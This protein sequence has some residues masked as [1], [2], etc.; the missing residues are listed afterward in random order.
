MYKLNPISSLAYLMEYFVVIIRFL[1]R[2]H[3][4]CVKTFREII[5]NN[6]SKNRA[7]TALKIPLKTIKLNTKLAIF[8]HLEAKTKRS[9][10][11]ND[12]LRIF[13]ARKA[14][15]TS[16]FRESRKYHRKYYF[17]ALQTK[18]NSWMHA[19]IFIRTP[20]SFHDL[21]TFN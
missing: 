16:T 2:R 5:G 10:I 18:L 1:R 9:Q 19:H 8:G 4:S 12:F 20:Y 21:V 6:H 14:L 17:L 11:N 3:K 13:R 7:K 15:S